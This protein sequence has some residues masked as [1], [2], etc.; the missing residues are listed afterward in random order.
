M[1][2]TITTLWVSL[3][4]VLFFAACAG[5]RQAPVAQKSQKKVLWDENRNPYADENDN[6][7]VS[8]LDKEVTSGSETPAQGTAEAAAPQSLQR[9]AF[10]VEEYSRLARTGKGTI[11]GRIYLIGPY[12][13]KIYGAKTRLYLNPVTSYSRQWYQQSYLN[14]HKMGKADP[15]L[16][17]Y[18]RF[19]ASDDQGSF[20]FY[21]VPSGSYYLIGTVSCGTQCGYE[22]P[23]SIRI[24]K[25]VRI[26]GNQVIDTDLSRPVQ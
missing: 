18:L 1:F 25:E 8:D 20:A 6:V 12:G 24:A 19:T 11:Q 3:L 4:I 2:K 17:N 15:R 9:I 7:D 13:D 22:T 26:E 21:G 14:G 23:K 10:P 5:Q 16:F